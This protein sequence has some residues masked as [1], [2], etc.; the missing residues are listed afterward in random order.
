MNDLTINK[1]L[2]GG[3][4]FMPEMHLR[5]FAFRCRACGPF[6]KCKERMQN[7]LKKQEIYDIFIQ[8]NWAKLACSVT[9]F[10]EILRIWLEKQ[11]L[12]NYHVIKNF[13]LLK[14]QYMIDI[15]VDL[16]Q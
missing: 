5:Q 16:L 8:T 9:W 3:D 4:R 10:M 12:R 1:F 11:L 15:N 7:F 13:L 6:T 2:L 14:I